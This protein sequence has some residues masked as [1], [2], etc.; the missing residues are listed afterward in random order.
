MTEMFDPS[1]PAVALHD[2]CKLC[3]SAATLL[4]GLPAAK[5][6]GGP[7]PDA[8]DDCWYYQ[9]ERCDFCFT[10]ALDVQDHVEIYDET[11]WHN[12]DPDWYGRVSQ[13]LRLAALANELRRGHLPELEMLDFGCGIGA[14]VEV[15][16]R[17][18]GLQVWGHDIIPPKVGQEWFLP[19]LG[20]RKFDVITACEVIEHLPDPRAIFD[21]IR[22]HLKPGGVFTFQT[23]YWDPT[24]LGRDWWYLGPG[25]GHISL[26][27][28]RGL[29]YVFSAMKGID[30]RLWAG[31]AG[32]QAWQFA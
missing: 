10:R 29:S 5:M 28:E 21:L 24:T 20:D 18:L 4:F 1:G 6:T 26:Y 11:Y 27:S 15:A 3:G 12:Q 22:A 2:T 14:F 25:N 30:R 23:A 13:T 9:C 17:D 31:Y 19:A 16:R 32:V 7:I 8:P